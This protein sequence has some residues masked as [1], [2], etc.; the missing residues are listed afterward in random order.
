MAANLMLL[1]VAAAPGVSDDSRVAAGWQTGGRSA[2]CGVCAALRVGFSATGVV[3]CGASSYVVDSVSRAT[4][5]SLAPD[6]D[7]WSSAEGMMAGSLT[8]WSRVCG[9]NGAMITAMRRFFPIC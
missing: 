1:R 4:A 9:C 6:N 7:W 3:A 5:H 2:A 8:C